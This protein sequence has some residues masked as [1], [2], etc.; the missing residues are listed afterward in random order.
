[1][2]LPP[3]SYMK[4]A[5]IND[6]NLYFTV[7]IKYAQLKCRPCNQSFTLLPAW[8]MASSFAAALTFLQ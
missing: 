8:I 4:Q 1:M 5:Y 2:I 3:V 6:T 7:E